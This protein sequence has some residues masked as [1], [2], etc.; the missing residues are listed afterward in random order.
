MESIYVEI[1]DFEVSLTGGAA[2]VRWKT[3]Y[4]D[5]IA[6]WNIYRSVDGGDYERINGTI[7]APYQYDYEFSD[8]D[9][10]P[11]HSYCYRL[12]AV[13]LAGGPQ[14]FGIECADVPDTGGGTAPF[15]TDTGADDAEFD[16]AGGCGH[17]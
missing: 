4:E 17:W 15:E 12:E 9:I 11:S 16:A 2:R 13:N 6:G 10:S 8:T 7:I 5:S 1:E 3:S 14:T